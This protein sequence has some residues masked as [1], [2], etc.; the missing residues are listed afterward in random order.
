MQATRRIRTGP[1]P[2]LS[3]GALEPRTLEQVTLPRVLLLA[4]F[5]LLS[6]QVALRGW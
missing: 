1:L 5:A 4:F 2:K 3:P 6:I